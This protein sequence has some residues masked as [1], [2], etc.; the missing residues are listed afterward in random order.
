MGHYHYGFN[1]NDEDF[2]K[3]KDRLIH[4]PKE[5][6][7]YDGEE[8]QLLPVYLA[9]ACKANYSSNHKRVVKLSLRDIIYTMG[10]EPRR[11][12][13]NINE[14]VAIAANQL[15]ELGCF[16]DA[17]DYFEHDYIDTKTKYRYEVVKPKKAKTYVTITPFEVLAVANIARNK[18]KYDDNGNRRR[19]TFSYETM[20]RVL[21]TLRLKILDSKNNI[22]LISREKLYELT[23]VT[24]Q[25]ITNITTELDKAGII[26]K[27]V[28]D[29]HRDKTCED[30]SVKREKWQVAF[31]SNYYNVEAK[32][33]YDAFKE[34]KDYI[35]YQ[36]S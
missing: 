4:V 5:L 27:R 23:G 30:G 18:S 11:G 20:V 26:R 2:E 9:V 15:R 35:G 24:P 1:T 6:I 36:D 21:L 29:L 13:G 3:D 34:Y 31:Y 7:L 14:Q 25:T 12:K 17:P 16:K 22:L 28:F 19:I 8:K 32:A 33:V 10:L